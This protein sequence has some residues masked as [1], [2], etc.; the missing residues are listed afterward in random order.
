MMNKLS[1]SDSAIR[2]LENLASGS[3]DDVKSAAPKRGR[4]QSEMLNQLKP[5]NSTAETRR[6]DLRSSRFSAGSAD[7][8]TNSAQAK[9]NGASDESV[10]RNAYE[11]GRYRVDQDQNLENIEAS[12]NQTPAYPAQVDEVAQARLVEIHQTQLKNLRDTWDRFIE[13]I[14]GMAEQLRRR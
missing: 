9:L 14:N 3:T 2:P 8:N 6:T 7:E 13:H 12:M 4:S 11:A 5:R 1:S 10:D